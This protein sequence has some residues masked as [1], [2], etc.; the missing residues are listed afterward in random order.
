MSSAPDDPSSRPQSVVLYVADMPG[1]I[2]SVER[3]AAIVAA[4][5]R[6]LCRPLGLTEV[7]DSRS[8]WPR[9]PP[10]ACCTDAAGGRVPRVQDATTG[11][12]RRSVLGLIGSRRARTIDPN[13]LRSHAMNW[14]DSLASRTG[15]AVRIA[16]FVRRARVTDRPSRLP[17]G[18]H[19][20]AA[21]MW[22]ARDPGPRHGPRQGHCW[23]GAASPGAGRTR[24]STSY[25]QH[26]VVGPRDLS[27]R[28]VD[29]RRHEGWSCDV[30]EYLPGEASIAAPLRADGRQGGRLDLGI[31]GPVDRVCDAERP[32]PGAP[33][34]CWSATPHGRS[35]GT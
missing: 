11:K 2:Q 17:A 26:T 30:E 15:E 4:G 32:A 25:T 23:P 35:R 27:R 1:S 8:T 13:D 16:A 5:G 28:L 9:P 14:A 7:A 12:L 34:R 10:T 19:P 33:G 31:T 3:A 6:E 29:V 22:A 18:R 24:S 21:P 20:P